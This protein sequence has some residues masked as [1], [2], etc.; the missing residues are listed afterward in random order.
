MGSTLLQQCSNT[1]FKGVDVQLDLGTQEAPHV[2]HYPPCTMDSR[3]VQLSIFVNLTLLDAY[4]LH[5]E[6]HLSSDYIGDKNVPSH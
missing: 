4:Y 1:G 3:G 5:K 6:K 2:E